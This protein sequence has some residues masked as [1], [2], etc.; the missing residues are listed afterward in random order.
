VLVRPDG[1]VAWRS[2]GA[3]ADAAATLEQVVAR[4]LGFELDERR[5]VVASLAGAA[6]RRS[7]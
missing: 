5:S 3:A 7:A 4:V 6:G 1:H 2:V